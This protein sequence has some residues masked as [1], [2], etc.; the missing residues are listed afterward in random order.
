[1]SK[2][3]EKTLEEQ[4]SSISKS[5]YDIERTL[6]EDKHK[7]VALKNKQE[8]IRKAIECRE[9]DINYEHHWFIRDY[10]KD[11]SFGEIC[12]YYIKK[13][14]KILISEF[15]SYARECEIGT[16]IRIIIE[17]DRTTREIKVESDFTQDLYTKYLKPITEK[18]VK[19]QVKLAMHLAITDLNK[20][21]EHKL[22]CN[23]KELDE[24]ATK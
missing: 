14:G 6:N 16:Y 10:R 13:A 23:V 3:E 17:K 21:L 19:L 2:K 22:I 24:P 15:G 4:Y 1:M 7:L 5:I 12:F 11:K 8:E 9:K 18:E 20:S